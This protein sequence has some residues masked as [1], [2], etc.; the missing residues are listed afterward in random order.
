MGRRSANGCLLAAVVWIVIVG[1]LA[2]AAKYFILPYFQ[3]EL[4]GKTGSA[5]RYK[6]EITIAADSFSG[7]SILRSP[8]MRK[9]LKARGIKLNI[10]DDNAD[11]GA[12]MKA[13]RDGKIQMAVFTVDSF[14]TAGAK[15]GTFP[16]T[17]VMVIDETKGADA[18]VAYKST[19]PSIQELDH[20]DA[21]IVLTP[22]SPSEFLARTIIAHFNLP[23]LP[24]RWWVEA[25][26]AA[27][28]YRKFKAAD[29]KDRRV[30]ALWEPYVSK[31][32]EVPGAHVLL[33]SSKLKGYIVDVLV[34]QRKFM[35][36]HPELVK[37]VVEAYLRAAYAYGQKTGGMQALVMED[38]KSTGSEALTPEQATKLVKGIEWKN[39]LENYG[40][41]GLLSAQE[42]R[43]L[44]HIEDIILNITDVLVKTGAIPGDPV[45]GSAHTLFYDKTL[46]ELQADNFHPGKKVSVI[47]GVG[48]G[49]EDL[50]QVRTGAVL[51]SLSEAEWASLSPVGRMRVEPIAFTRGTARISIQSKRDL[52]RLAR[53][54]TAWP[55]YYLIIV[56]HARAEGNPEA[57]LRL[58]GK[59]ADAA[60]SHLITAGID[61]NRIKATAAEPSG[62]EGAAQS[63]SFILGQIPY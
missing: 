16:A 1:I 20:P 54:L 29:K 49:T 12:R 11:Y 31:S 42:A 6:H 62:R 34:A 25:D 33:D 60:A 52:D 5:S 10:V 47:E 59:R 27:D 18:L 43:G 4:V 14:I 40:Y 7:Y 9:Q 46:R 45:A 2:V 58:A 8:L 38:A 57:N 15:L 61:R 37:S 32:L 22:E 41:F 24:D 53:N 21:R 28:V 44:Q 36:D 19:V 63:V 26:G 39:T 50:G 17:I 3:K 35:R 13:L 23:N 55:E 56:G 51:R 48:L 30:Y